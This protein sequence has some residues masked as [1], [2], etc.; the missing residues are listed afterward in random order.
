MNNFEQEPQPD[1]ERQF[2]VQPGMIADVLPR[3]YE[4]CGENPTYEPVR[5]VMVDGHEVAWME[6]RGSVE[7][8]ITGRGNEGKSFMGRVLCCAC[9][10]T[11]GIGWRQEENGQPV[12][13]MGA[14]DCIAKKTAGFLRELE[15]KAEYK[16]YDLQNRHLFGDDIDEDMEKVAFELIDKVK[17]GEWLE[18]NDGASF[19][20]G[21]YYLQTLAAVTDLPMKKIWEFAD[22]MVAEK[23]ISLEGAV[24]QEYYE[25]PAPAWSEPTLA[26][27]LDGWKVSAALP[28]HGNMAQEWKFEV[29]K[30]DGKKL[31]IEIAGEPLLHQP[32]FGPDVGDV[33]KAEERIVKIMDEVRN[34]PTD[35]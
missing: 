16:S 20:G 24:V 8:D 6:Y 25:P 31:E 29:T 13:L 30:P 34:T 2:G 21:Y 33:A 32:M 4:A 18:T 22:K 19:W 11:E 26:Y 27:E 10:F 35:E 9:Q 1:Q 28:V 17:A 5:S 15:L 12:G 23:K 14:D 3:Y 7:H